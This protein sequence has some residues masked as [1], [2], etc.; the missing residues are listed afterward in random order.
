M[1]MKIYIYKNIK[2]IICDWEIKN[3]ARYHHTYIR[4]VKF[5]AHD[6]HGY[7]TIGLSFIVSGN[8]KFHSQVGR[9]FGRFFQN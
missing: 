9:Q 2:N 1:K 6:W 8:A 5:P 7:R 4:I 3:K